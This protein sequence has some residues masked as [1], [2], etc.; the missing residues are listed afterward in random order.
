MVAVYF[1]PLSKKS[2]LM[3]DVLGVS[4]FTF[5]INQLFVP[6]AFRA[7]LMAESLSFIFKLLI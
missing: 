4:P 6:L 5:P 2:S 3:F 7:N 1:F